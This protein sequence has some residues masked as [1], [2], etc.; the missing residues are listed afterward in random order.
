MNAVE[1]S[2]CSRPAAFTRT[3]PELASY[4]VTVRNNKV[5]MAPEDRACEVLTLHSV[6]AEAIEFA[7]EN[8]HGGIHFKMVRPWFRCGIRIDQFPR[9]F[10]R[11]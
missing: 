6:F 4:S 9:P 1:T 8:V 3:L 11:F 2:Q 10:A 7:D 5:V